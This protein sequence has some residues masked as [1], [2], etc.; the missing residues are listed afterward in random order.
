[1]RLTPE[2]REELLTRF[3]RAV[4]LPMLLLAL[5]LI[6]LLAL[7]LLVDLPA[8]FGKAFAAVDWLIWAAFAFEYAV[9]LG[10]TTDRRR[11]VLREWPDLLIVTLPLLRPL[12][13]AR[14]ARSLRLLRMAR[15]A[16][17]LAEASQESRQLLLRH[18]LHYV[19]LAT[20]LVVTASAGLM[21]Q[22]EREA[23]G[24]IA[25]FGDALWWAVTTVTTVG[26]GDTYPVTEAGRGIAAFLMLVGI[27]LFGVLTAN[28]A[29]FLLE[30]GREGDVDRLVARLDE[31]AR[32]LEVLEARL[33][34]CGS[35]G[36]SRAG[37]RSA[38]EPPA[39]DWRGSPRP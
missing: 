31:I 37:E 16:A 39:R 6:P 25:S 7:P 24:S 29:A 1:M 22:V 17:V 14:S 12:R 3:E 27:A 33:N 34:E 38:A 8:P 4:E 36:G 32:R 5:A 30:R 15:L 13:L 21:L 10:L 28:L 26:Y 20:L 23:G 35:A 19:L 18:R 9:R 11:F 2:R